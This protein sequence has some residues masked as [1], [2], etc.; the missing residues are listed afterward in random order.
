MGRVFTPLVAGGADCWDWWAVLIAGARGRLP[1][2]SRGDVRSAGQ[3]VMSSLLPWP[4][5]DCALA[6]CVALPWPMLLPRSPQLVY[7]AGTGPHSRCPG[8][9]T[10]SRCPVAARRAG[11]PGPA[12]EDAAGRPDPAAKKLYETGPSLCRERQG[13]LRRDDGLAAPVLSTR[14]RQPINACPGVARL[15]ARA[16]SVTERLVRLISV[17]GAERHDSL[18]NGADWYPDGCCYQS[19][20][21]PTAAL[22]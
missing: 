4:A 7:A 11:R 6:L 9:T 22:T 8:T 15:T 5:A 14:G 12:A 2:I 21:A 16:H 19:F 1:L 17:I 13:A 20:A 10:R 3:L 18:A